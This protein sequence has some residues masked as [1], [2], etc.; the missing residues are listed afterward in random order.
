MMMMIILERVIDSRFTQHVN[1]FDL[2]SSFQSAYRKTETALVKVH[3]DIISAV[4]HGNL[5]ALV[6]LD[7][8]S[9]FDT[10]DHQ[11]FLSI[12]QRRFGVADSALNWFNSYLSGR[13]RSIV[14]RI[15]HSCSSLWCSSRFLSWPKDLYHLQ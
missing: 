4:D 10:V 11:T 13:T 3:N 6:A 7:F 12:L 8:S 14:W 1:T 5:G 9:A 15:R 2:L